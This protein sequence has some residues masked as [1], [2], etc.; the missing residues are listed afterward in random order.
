[1]RD[2]G[3][4]AEATEREY[5]Q[6]ARYAGEH[7]LCR[8]VVTETVVDLGSY[9]FDE[10]PSTID[11][12]IDFFASARERTPAEYRDA[13]KVSLEFEQDYYDSGASASLSISYERPETD[14]EMKERFNRYMAYIRH[15]EQ[16][17]RAQYEHLKRKFETDKS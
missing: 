2:K 14:V 9:E 11:G 3:I 13:L 4:F 15:G 16:E 7:S 12:A 6:M 8:Q 10:F 17:E 1:M 5:R